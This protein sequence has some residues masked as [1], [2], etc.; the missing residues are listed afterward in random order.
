MASEIP[1]GSPRCDPATLPRSLPRITNPLSKPPR[2][3]GTRLGAP[4][5][6]AL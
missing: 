6:P 1:F 4:E 2:P 5:G 3:L